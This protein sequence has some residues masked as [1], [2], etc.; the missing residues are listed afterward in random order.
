MLLRAAERVNGS[1]PRRFKVIYAISENRRTESEK[2][3]AA[4]REK[5]ILVATIPEGGAA[6][7]MAKVNIVIVGAEIITAQGG[8]VSRL[9]TYQL[10]KLAKMD[11]K[12]F[13]VAAEQHKLGQTF[14]TT[15]FNYGVPAFRQDLLEFQSSTAASAQNGAAGAGA[16]GLT[17]DEKRAVYVQSVSPLDF[18]P[19]DLITN[20]I[21]DHG[22]K[23]T[24]AMEHQVIDMFVS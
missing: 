6:Y 3:V 20:F 2:A 24:V 5:G 4:L 22:V 9:G 7:I 13:Y 23:S 14:P 8:I 15:Q 1:P 11:R 10:A 12:P 17:A 21:C 19:P 18:T 16:D